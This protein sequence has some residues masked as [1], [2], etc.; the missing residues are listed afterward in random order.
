MET[1]RGEESKTTPGV[2]VLV[3]IRH[4]RA[5]AKLS[6]SRRRRGCERLAKIAG[7]FGV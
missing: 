5:L 6:V 2:G 1:R 7:G 3:G 4:A